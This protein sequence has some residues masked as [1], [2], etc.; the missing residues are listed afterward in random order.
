VA[1]FDPIFAADPNNPELVA[2]NASILIFDP[3]DPTRAPVPI[4]DA[5]GVP[6]PNPV[7]VNDKGWGPAFKTPDGPDELFRVGWS[8]ADF[9]GFFTSYESMRDAA[10]NAKAAAQEAAANAAEAVS[11]ALSGSTAAASEAA[12]SAS[13]AQS[14]AASALAAAQAAQAAAEAA[15]AASSG[16]GV[17]IDPAD[18]DALILSTKNDGS[19]VADP[20][21]SDA[22]IITT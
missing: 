2:Q 13:S 11:E 5:T 6:L 22:L 4:T 1:T 10:V 7:T 16:G 19:V 15:A 18:P 12:S 3:N 21:D 9:T 14:Q 8:G 17:A 20:S